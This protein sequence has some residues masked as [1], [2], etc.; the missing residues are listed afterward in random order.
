MTVYTV[1]AE[2]VDNVSGP[3]KAAGM[4]VAAL[5]EEMKGI[6]VKGLSSE[7]TELASIIKGLAEDS[8]AASIASAAEAKGL[9]DQAKGLAD[10]KKAASDSAAASEKLNTAMLGVAGAAASAAI[11]IG[12]GTIKLMAFT[13][14]AVEAKQKMISMFDALGGGA[15]S[16]AATLKMIDALGNKIGT[17]R[18]QMG[19]WAQQL[20]SMGVTDLPALEKGMIAAASATAMMGDAGGGAFMELQRKIQGAADAGGK[21]TLGAEALTGMSK[22][23]VTASE[24]AKTL[25]MDVTDLNAQLKGGTMD[26]TKFGNALNETL[27]NKGA[28]P[29]AK[30][31]N[32]LASLTGKFK[33]SMA[34]LFEDVDIGDFMKE[35]K[36]LLGIFSQATP[37]GKALKA[38]VGGAFNAIFAAASVVVPLVKNFLLDVVIFSLKAAIAF[39]PLIKGVKDFM[40]QGESLGA[41]KSILDAMGTALT[42]LASQVV[43]GVIVVGAIVAAF[44]ALSAMLINAGAAVVNFVSGAIESIMSLAPKALSAGSDFVNS[45][46]SGITAG[47][48]AVVGAVKGLADQAS[49]AFKAVFGMSGGA[50]AGGGAAALPAHA[51]GGVVTGITNGVATVSAAAGEG[52]ASIGA[53][54]AIVPAADVAASKGSSGGGKNINIQATFTFSGGSGAALEVTEEAISL[55]FERM[56]LESGL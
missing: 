30:M 31:G 29:L 44:G 38:A 16:G 19:P 35:M 4:N 32:S 48:G 42:F 18:E 15:S 41:T 33:E 21:L 26:A 52:L 25:G 11:A 50:S 40:A 51:T 12:A 47:A 23:G 3:A 7:M 36:G 39:K 17:T 34:M 5:S 8:K 20:M 49:G 37:S 55:I 10:Q 13:V 22:M 56:A 45:L 28:G 2:L 54:E 24:V 14:G 46:V 43:T 27:T 9:A 53:G 6:P 1:T